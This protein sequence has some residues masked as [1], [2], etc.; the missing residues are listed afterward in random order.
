MSH[1][2]NFG[3][4]TVE[5]GSQSAAYTLTSKFQ[6]ASFGHGLDGLDNTITAAPVVK[7]GFTPT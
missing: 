1:T 7:S 2:N 4:P 6:T 5:D 3:G